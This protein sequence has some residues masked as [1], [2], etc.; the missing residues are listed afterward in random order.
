MAEK[1]VVTFEKLDFATSTRQIDRQTDIKK[2]KSTP[3]RLQYFYNN[4][5][6]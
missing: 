3:G 6:K 4:Y 2:A 5:F 1:Q